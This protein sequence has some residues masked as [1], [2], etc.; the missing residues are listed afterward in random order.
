L[1]CG[2]DTDR[3]PPDIIQRSGEVDIGAGFHP[4]RWI[5]VV[6]LAIPLFL[7]VSFV[8]A[9]LVGNITAVHVAAKGFRF[10][11][12][13]ELFGLAL[14][15]VIGF[16]YEHRSEK[17][18]RRLYPPPGQLVDIG[19][20]RLHL[21]CEGKGP[22]V[23]LEYGHQGSYTD[24]Y[25]VQPQLAEFTRVCVYD[26][27]GYGWSDPSPKSR[28]PSVMAEE[29][30]AVLRA[31]GEKPPYILVGHSF[32]GLT[33]LMFAHKFPNDV[34]GI[35]LVDA[36]LP[37]MMS[38]GRWQH[39]ARIRWMQMAV[40]IGLARWRGWCGGN[41]V[42]E[43]RELKQAITCHPALYE[44]YRREWTSFP[45]SGA[46]IRAIAGIESIPLIVIAR[47]AP[48]ERSGDREAQWNRLQQ[49][50]TKLSSNSEFVVA[51]GSRHDV[52][53]DRPDVI[54][55]AVRKVVAQA[56]GTAGHPGNSVR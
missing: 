35:V 41:A 48:A 55:A 47:E 20:Y 8:A 31:A 24:W 5:L 53:G 39:L 7:L 2:A 18:D 43:I 30:H 29:L 22:T 14:I 17:D 28:V 9:K 52:P 12:S 10:V 40:M 50:R 4:V 38:T 45:E 1:P 34:A 25:R 16:V 49:E 3:E 11:L 19:G 51:Q 46:E 54:V 36:S 13:F 37:E 15:A 23:V 6:G 33:S 56:S 26:R 44:T 42:M 21:H 27:G 32:G